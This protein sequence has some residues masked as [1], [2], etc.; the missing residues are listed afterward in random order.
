[1]QNILTDRL[2]K[3][4]SYGKRIRR[5]K[6]IKL[7]ITIAIAIANFSDLTSAPADFSLIKPDACHPP[8]II[9]TYLQHFPNSPTSIPPYRNY[10]AGDYT[11]LYSTLSACDWSDVYNSTSVDE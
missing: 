1:M 11:L 7:T 6:I 10:L 5:V 2:C 9:S 8:L 3:A 4:L